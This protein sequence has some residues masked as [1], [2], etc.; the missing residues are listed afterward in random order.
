MDPRGP[1]T[2]LGF[3]IM[4]QA[5]YANMNLPDL[6]GVQGTGPFKLTAS[7]SLHIAAAVPCREVELFQWITTQFCPRQ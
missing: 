3:C 4:M 6:F 1:R 2:L 7:K 5:D